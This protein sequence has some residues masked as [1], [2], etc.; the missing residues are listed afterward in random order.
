MRTILRRVLKALDVR[1]VHEAEDGRDAFRALQTFEP[2][3]AIVDWEMKP[4]NGIEF[5]KAVRRRH[6]GVNPFMPIIMLSAH[7]EMSR[8]TAARDAGVNEFVVKPISVKAL[9]SRIEAI[10]E[11]PRPFVRAETYFGPERRRR[12]ARY[13]GPDRRG[14]EAG[15]I[16]ADRDSDANGALPSVDAP[17]GGT[18][19]LRVRH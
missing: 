16:E 9:F 15:V 3:I 18:D 11:R 19:E 17:P 10:I 5:V 2:D 6:D 12:D 4:M 14:Q 13:R 8:V 7:S 1:A